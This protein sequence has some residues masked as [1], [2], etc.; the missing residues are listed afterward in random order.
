[1]VVEPVTHGMDPDSVEALGRLLT[2]RADGLRHMT[3]DVSAAVGRLQWEGPVG[4]HFKT[5]VWPVLRVSIGRCANDLE[6]FGR[7][8]L[9]NA[10]EQRGASSASGDRGGAPAVVALPAALPAGWAAMSVE[11]RALFLQQAGWTGGEKAWAAMSPADQAALIERYKGPGDLAAFPPEVRYAINHRLVQDEASRLEAKQQILK[12]RYSRVSRAHLSDEELGRLALY[13]RILDPTN[14]QKVLFFDPSGDGRIAV[15]QG[16]LVNAPNVA[17]QVPGISNTLAKY[18]S[19]LTEGQNLK[20]A[21]GGNTAVVTW[22]GYDTPVS[23]VG[24]NPVRAWD[25]ISNSKMASAGADQLSSFVGDIDQHRPDARIT[26]IGHSYGSHVTGLAAEQGMPADV[27][28]F[29]GSPG[30]GVEKVAAFSHDSRSPEVY[31]GQNSLDPISVGT[32]LTGIGD[33]SHF[34]T[35]PIAGTFGAVPDHVRVFGVTNVSHKYYEPRSESLDWLGDIAGNHDGSGG[36]G[37]GEGW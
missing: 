10:S 6:G 23:A 11:D 4:Q 33:Q 14:P 36:G 17:V 18:G 27:V 26:V 12:A 28:V 34:S 37:G 19:L 16:D 25:E 20:A 7:S 5:G 9:N 2:T 22:L 13:K 29:I 24:L 21:A 1:M 15:V 3:S 30:T 8:A 32:D 31:V 35:D